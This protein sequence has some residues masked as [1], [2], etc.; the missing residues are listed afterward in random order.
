MALYIPGEIM[1]LIVALIRSGIE[2][3]GGYTDEQLRQMAVD[4]EARSDALQK[5]QEEG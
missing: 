3:S 4:E 2:L 1:A 5:R